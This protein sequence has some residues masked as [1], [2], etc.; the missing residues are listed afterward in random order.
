MNTLSQTSGMM[1]CVAL[2]LSTLL[3]SE[4]SICPLWL[5]EEAP[6]GRAMPRWMPWVLL[7]TLGV[8]SVVGGV[9]YPLPA[10]AAFG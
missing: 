1:V 7:L 6:A 2:A 8:A 10:A 5:Q 3:G 4:A 9:L